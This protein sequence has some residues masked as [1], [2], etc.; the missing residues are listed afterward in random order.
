MYIFQI[1]K[2]NSKH[3]LLLSE[4]TI[5][6]SAAEVKFNSENKAFKMD[7]IIVSNARLQNSYWSISIEELATIS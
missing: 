1:E 6:T 4:C 3:F 2:T 7:M 5:K